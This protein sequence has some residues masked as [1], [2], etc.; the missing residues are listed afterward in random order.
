MSEIC[1]LC[2]AETNFIMESKILGK[3]NISYYDCPNCGYVQTE[4]PYWLSEAYAT[5][6][7]E[8]DTGIISRNYQNSKILYFLLMYIYRLEFKKINHI[9]HAAGYGMLVGLLRELGIKSYW[10]D[11]YCENI[12]AKNYIHDG[13]KKNVDVISAFEVFEHFENPKTEINELLINCNNLI[14]STLIMPEKP[15]AVSEWWY[16]GVEHGQHIGFFREKTLIYLAK[17]N[18][19]NIY[20]DG[21]SIH[22][23]TSKKLSLMFFKFVCFFARVSMITILKR[24][25]RC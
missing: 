1:R 12:F 22:C 8:W 2:H 19:L 25:C 5:P 13:S 14:F 3:Y 11:K 18:N 4:K 23:L 9:D 20:S 21:Y 16:Y 24:L 17:I 6:I 7:N 10:I 15:P